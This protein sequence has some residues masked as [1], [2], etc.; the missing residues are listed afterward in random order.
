ME[1]GGTLLLAGAGAG[2]NRSGVGVIRI[3]AAEDLRLPRPGAASPLK[4][5]RLQY[6]WRPPQ[7]LDEQL[8]AGFALALQ[9]VTGPDRVRRFYPP[10]SFEGFL[11]QAWLG[12]LAVLWQRQ[13]LGGAELSSY[14]AMRLLLLRVRRMAEHFRHRFD[15]SQELTVVPSGRTEAGDRNVLPEDLG[16]DARGRGQGWGGQGADPAWRGAGPPGRLPAADHRPGH[17]SR[18]GRGRP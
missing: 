11:A 12:G 7:A 6:T 8:P 14:R 3:E 2:R 10:N 17:P 5:R 15:S 9:C 13:H 1:T 18:P 16:L 4:L